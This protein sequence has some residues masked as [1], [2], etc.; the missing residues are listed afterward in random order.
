M[1]GGVCHSQGEGPYARR[2]CDLKLLVSETIVYSVGRWV[3]VFAGRG[4]TREVSWASRTWF[5]GGHCCLR[6]TCLE[7]QAAVC[8][9]QEAAPAHPAVADPE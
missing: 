8:L 6:V 5:G 4:R 1:G 3:S 2:S 7:R 9:G